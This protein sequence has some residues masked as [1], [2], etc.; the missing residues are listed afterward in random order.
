[1]ESVIWFQIQT[2][3]FWPSTRPNMPFQSDALEGSDTFRWQLWEEI[4]KAVLADNMGQGKIQWYTHRLMHRKKVTCELY[5][6][7]F[8]LMTIKPAIPKIEW[9]I[10]LLYNTV[11]IGS[12]ELEI[13]WVGDKMW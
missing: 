2:R 12:Q 7:Y 11:M 10:E 9:A 4:A 8:R 13:R 3:L 5:D 6:S 1:M